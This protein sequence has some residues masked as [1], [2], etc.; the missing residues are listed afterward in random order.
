MLSARAGEESAIEGLEAGADDYLVKPFSAR[1]LR[2]RVRSNL[3]LAR[4]RLELSR[5]EVLAE[6]L[7]EAV[8]ARDEFLSI[9]SHELKT[10]LAAFR[11][12]LDLINREL[13]ADSLQRVRPRISSAGRQVQ[14]LHQLV[15]TLLDVSQLSTGRLTLHPEELD[16]SQLMAEMVERMREELERAGSQ[17]TLEAQAPVV[18]RYDRLRIEQ[19]MTNLLSNAARYGQGRPVEVRVYEVPDAV[20]LTVK[21]HGLG[22]APEDTRR[23]FERFERAVPGRHYG[24]LGLG[25]WVARQVVEAHGGRIQVDSAPGQ[26]STFTVELP[27]RGSPSEPRF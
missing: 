13:G 26:G 14:R 19:L 8:L 2:A 21:D 23:I 25:L 10:P 3:E 16:L 24:G 9:A 27:R 7:R 12:Q 18:G 15:E 11:L 17:V 1:E 20:L 4:M 22:I 6:G 5:Q